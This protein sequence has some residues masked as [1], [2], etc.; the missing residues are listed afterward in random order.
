LSASG[1]LSARL[2]WRR[3]SQRP[4]ARDVDIP[5]KRFLLVGAG[6]HGAMVAEE[7]LLRKGIRVVGFL[8]DD[9]SK[10]GAII[11]GV[12]VLGRTADLPRI[13]AEQR[14]DEVLV[15]ISPKSRQLL[16]LA[17]IDN[18]HG[19]TVHS[20]IIPTIDELLA[21]GGVRPEPALMQAPLGAVNNPPGSDVDN[22]NGGARVLLMP[23]PAKADD[24]G[25]GGKGNGNSF[26]SSADP[27]LMVDRP[28]AANPCLS[29]QN[30]TIVIT[31]G[32]GFIGSNLAEKLVHQNRL[33]LL[34]KSFTNAP[35]QYTDLL[36]HPNVTALEGDILTLELRTILKDANVVVHAAAILGV[37]RVCSAGRE[38]METN[39]VG[40]SRLLKA[41]DASPKLDRF[42]Y[43]ST[44]EVF[45]INSYRV[46]ETIRPSVGPIAESRWSY[47]MSKLAGEHLVASYFRETR[48]PVTIVRPFNV[49]G[50]RRTGDY[51]LRRFIVSA[52]R[53][54]PLEVHGDGT[55]IR[56]WCY[57]EDF[58]SAL[59]Q[60]IARQQA[61]G[62]DF[63]IGNPGNT[64]TVYELAQKVVHLAG[65]SSRV[66]LRDS[67]F[68]DVSI[69]VP[70][71][72]KAKRLLGYKP[73]Y[74]LNTG[75]KLTIDWYRRNLSD[76][77]A[78]KAIPPAS[79]LAEA[80]AYA[81]Q[82]LS[83]AADLHRVRTRR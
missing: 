3:L 2:M 8:D 11:A 46:D 15:C 30:K 60:M 51:A 26:C 47:A 68:P 70:S 12:K 55:Q 64:V 82:H 63:N 53:D 83:S 80:G 28:D 9:P 21:A 36:R 39:Y 40:T 25:H 29:V 43:F 38:T 34:D 75:L 20:R 13:V 59:L 41:L 44:S 14:V 17:D 65:S 81:F 18:G 56:A 7:M 48:L 27:G 54:D 19:A 24:G 22:G 35:I 1:G 79:A 42:V 76:L 57:I 31:G 37:D 71:L 69:R 52:L 73:Q 72:E 50:P 6:V 67:P 33:I 61:I 66:E 74:D 77:V 4:T 49:F 5:P 62:E 78:A 32:A 58:C 16:H 23:K 45:G 10:Q